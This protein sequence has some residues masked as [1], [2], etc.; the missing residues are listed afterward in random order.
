LE[1]SKCLLGGTRYRSVINSTD[2]PMDVPLGPLLGFRA[3]GREII[4]RS[5][6]SHLREGAVDYK[7]LFE[8]ENCLIRRL[9][10]DVYDEEEV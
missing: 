1:I 8:G 9:P 3:K 10:I 5:E 2:L 7:A 6:E 4:E